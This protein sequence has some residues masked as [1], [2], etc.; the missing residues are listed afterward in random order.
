MGVKKIYNYLAPKYNL[1]NL[2]DKKLLNF[3]QKIKPDFILTNIGGGTQEILGLYLKLNLIFYQKA[4]FVFKASC[5]N[6]N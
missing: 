1:N 5:C 2:S 3:A 4:I 6:Y